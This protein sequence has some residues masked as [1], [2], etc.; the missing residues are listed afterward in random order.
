MNRS[1]AKA[2]TCAVIAAAISA[3]FAAAAQ[4]TGSQIFN[5]E[6]E[7]SAVKVKIESRQASSAA[8]PG[9]NVGYVPTVTNLN[10]SS[11]IRVKFHVFANGKECSLISA[12]SFYGSGSRWI[13]KGD[14]YYSTT[15]FRKGEAA[16]VVRGIRIPE[17][18]GTGVTDLKILAA[19]D[20]IQARNFSPDFN[21]ENPWG[22]VEIQEEADTVRNAEYSSGKNVAGVAQVSEDMD[23][24]YAREGIFECSTEDLFSR[25]DAFQPGDT[26]SEMLNMKNDSDR[27]MEI[28]FRT[29]NQETELLDRMQLEISCCGS[30]VYSGSLTSEALDSFIQIGTVMPGHSGRLEF[31]ISMPAEAD[32]SFARLKDNVVWIIAV[33]GDE[34]H[35]TGTESIAKTGDGMLPLAVMALICSIC[36]AVAA[37][38]LM[39]GRRKQ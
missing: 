27:K 2:A 12:D 8:E 33:K 13:K 37:A 15:A 28:Y 11:Y 34:N 35:K 9:E 1:I 30:R 25:F 18:I 3:V 23:F 5:N 16:E 7:T 36:I 20:A 17:E 26:C 10:A 22:T 21:R 14:F 4:F 31:E 32:N 38:S 39:A 29:E 24:T 6:F 19:A